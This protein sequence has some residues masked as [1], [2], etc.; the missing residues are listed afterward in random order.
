MK[1]G[2]FAS[3]ASRASVLKLG[4]LEGT[5]P[6]DDLESHAWLGDLS[7]AEGGQKVWVYHMACRVAGG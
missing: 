3:Q 4:R 2:R 6:P 7:V 5:R 1:F